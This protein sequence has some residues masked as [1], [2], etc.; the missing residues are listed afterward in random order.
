MLEAKRGDYASI[1]E[2]AMVASVSRQTAFRWLQEA[3]IDLR[4]ARNKYLAKL[5][6]A[7]QVYLARFTGAPRLTAEQKHKQ[8]VDAVSRLNAVQ[9]QRSVKKSG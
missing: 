6:V 8:L 2:I 1:A 9:V 7:E 3:G 5:Y 4:A